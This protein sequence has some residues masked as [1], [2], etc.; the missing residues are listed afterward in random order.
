MGYLEVRKK[1]KIH[2]PTV[3]KKGIFDATKKVVPIGIIIL[4][5]FSAGW[6][7]GDG[8]IRFRPFA[9]PSVNK[10]LPTH[11][12]YSSVDAIYQQI[13][14]NYDGKL[15]ETQ[16]LDGI[17]TGLA[18]ST[19]DPYTEY[20]NTKSATDFNNELGGTFEGIGAE[21]GKN[22][23]GNVIIIA[24]LAGYP[25]EKAGLK[26][27]DIIAKVDDK[28]TDGLTIDAVVTLIRGKASTT[29]KLGIV[30]DNTAQDISITRET[31]TIP[32]VK[33]EI[34]DGIGIL[35]ISRF[36]SDTTELAQKAA[37]NFKSQNVKGV[38]LD[39]RGN[40][41]GYLDAAVGVSSLWLQNKT[42]L[43]ER[44]G[45]TIIQTYTSR[46]TATLAGIPTVV[47]IDGGSAS[48]S[49]ITA[50][51][52]HDNKAATLMGVK[53]FGKGSVQQPINLRD[54]SLLKVTIARWYTPDGKNIDKQGITPDK[55]VKLTE[56]E[57]KN[58]IDRQLETALAQLKQ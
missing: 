47:L 4:I 55:E 42:I 50:G 37:D 9:A 31:I 30:R 49:E 1:D 24:P 10:S 32:S 27:K 19:G 29:V 52:L 2:D 20:F 35:T 8:R 13:K 48:A 57:I 17:K 36:G 3:S 34:K 46:G 54:G 38:V 45:G 5:I 6:A 40:P 21:L 51:A 33:N 18:N 11:L 39:L 26:P 56:D 41:G 58:K 14:E 12:D 23:A 16:L 53:S 44:R 22:D 43:T 28:S 15:T 7:F 25:A